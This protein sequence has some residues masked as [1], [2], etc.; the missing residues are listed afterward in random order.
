MTTSKYLFSACTRHPDCTQKVAFAVEEDPDYDAV[1]D[2]RAVSE[3]LQR[4]ALDTFGEVYC[5][6]IEHLPGSLAIKRDE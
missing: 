3:G 4:I 1:T 6:G 5:V 2:R